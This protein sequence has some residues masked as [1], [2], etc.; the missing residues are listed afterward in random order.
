MYIWEIT[1]DS[2]GGLGMAANIVFTCNRNP[3]KYLGS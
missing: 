1:A 3:R 2:E